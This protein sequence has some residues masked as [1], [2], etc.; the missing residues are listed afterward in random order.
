MMGHMD[1]T[2]K[3]LKVGD[4]VEWR[5]QFYTIKAFKEERHPILGV[6]FIEFEEPLHLQDEQPHEVSVDLVRQ[7]ALDGIVRR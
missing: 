5:G 4:T 1:S 6:P 7:P 3:P 2:G